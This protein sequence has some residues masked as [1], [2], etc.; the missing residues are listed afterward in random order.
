MAEGQRTLAKATK[1][2]RGV[3][4]HGGKPASV[5]IEPAAADAGIVFRSAGVV[6]LSDVPALV[7]HVSDTRRCTTLAV[8]Q[9]RIRTVEH[10][11]AACALAGLDNAVIQIEGD[12]L[13]AADGSALPFLNLI[14]EAT[15]VEQDRERGAVMLDERVEVSGSAGWKLVAEPADRASFVFRF[16]GTRALDGKEVSFTPGVDAPE[17]VASAR[18]FCFE[19]EIQAL[20]DAGLGRGGNA[21]NV[22]VLRADGTAVNAERGP[23]EAARHKLLDLIGDFALA[24]KGTTIGSRIVAEGTGHAAHVESLRVFITKLRRMEVPLH[25]A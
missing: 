25:G 14:T 23:M 9:F 11:L 4:L 2:L 17:M 13:P 19:E 21:D 15:V 20:L 22:L 18:T 1:V 16:R 6:G 5:V 7:A 10:L 3:G 24:G 12:E 8:G